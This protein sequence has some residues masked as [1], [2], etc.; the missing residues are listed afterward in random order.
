MA[1]TADLAF[2]AAFAAG[3]GATSAWLASRPFLDLPTRHPPAVI[4]LQGAAQI[5]FALGPLLGGLS[6]GLA[7]WRLARGGRLAPDQVTALET[8][9]FLAGAACL[10]AGMLMGVRR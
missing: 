9:A 10:V 1:R 6:L 5:L 2:L 3:L 7:A 4:H 8:A